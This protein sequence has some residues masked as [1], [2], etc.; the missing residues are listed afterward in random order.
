MLRRNRCNHI[1]AS[2]LLLVLSTTALSAPR[3]H[4]SKGMSVG[5]IYTDNYNLEPD[6]EEGDLGLRVTPNVNFN[7]EGARM[8]LDFFFAP[9]FTQHTSSDGGSD[10]SNNL[11][12]NLNSELYEDVLFLDA[13]ANAFLSQRSSSSGNSGDG[14]DNNRDT[15]QTYTYVVSPY[16]RHRFKSYA[17]SELRFT[18]DGVV[19]T[20]GD[21]ENSTSDQ[22]KYSINSGTRF[23]KTPWGLEATY[24]KIDYDG[25]SDNSKVRNILGNLSYKLN[26]RWQADSYLGYEDNDVESSSDDPQS[27][28]WGVG[29]TWTPSARTFLKFGYGKRFFGSNF[30]FD[31]KHRRK[32]SAWTASLTHDLASSREEQLERQTF[33]VL[34]PFGNP[35]LDPSGQ[36]VTVDVDSF[37]LT[38]AWYQL[39]RFLTSYTLQG[40]RDTL[41]FNA[42]ASERDYLDFDRDEKRYGLSAR[43]SRGLTGVLRGNLTLGWDKFEPNGTLG[44]NFDDDDDNDTWVIA[45]GLTRQLTARSSLNLNVSHRDRSS[46]NPDDEYTENRVSLTLGTRW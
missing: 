15:T 23:S 39:D 21:A 40:R 43:W 2:S 26:R 35:V 44:T 18:R 30:Y 42:F 9:S 20:S 13:S 37:N 7:R 41:T 38:D 6:N 3:W 22:L 25:S 4:F 28:N 34:D 16:T 8:K 1:L 19:N 32:R 24:Q 46:D 11:T 45:A 14:A 29:A 17:D 31:L 5:A 10:F 33:G 27:I 36:P 12:A